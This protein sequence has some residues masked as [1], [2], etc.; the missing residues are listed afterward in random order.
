MMLYI[1][2]NQTSLYV[3]D[4]GCQVSV[5]IGYICLERGTTVILTFEGFFLPVESISN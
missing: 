4:Y 5:E 1:E 2:F 3:L